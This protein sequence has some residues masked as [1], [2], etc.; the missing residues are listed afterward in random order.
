MYGTPHCDLKVVIEVVD[1]SGKPIEGIK[2]VPA[3]DK[4]FYGGSDD[5][6]FKMIMGM[7]TLTTD[8]NGKVK[9][10]YS[11]QSVPSA[12]KVY[13]EDVDG[14]KN[15]GTFAKDSAWF[16]K[17]KTGEDNTRDFGWYSGEWTISGKK[18]LK[19]K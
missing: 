16:Y 12:V 18:S 19:K 15:R 7:D 1:Q 10:T 8:K 17:I 3:A 13:F 4:E 6:S 14:A 2:V 5:R 9:H 11:V